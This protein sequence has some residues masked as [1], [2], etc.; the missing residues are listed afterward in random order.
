MVRS[1]DRVARMVRSS[2]RGRGRGRPG[3]RRSRRRR[4]GRGE[5]R[6]GRWKVSRSRVV[7]REKAAMREATRM[8]GPGRGVRRE[9]R[10]RRRRRRVWK[11]RRVSV[12]GWIG[13]EVEMMRRWRRKASEVRIPQRRE[14]TNW[15]CLWW[16]RYL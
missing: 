11:A 5:L 2:A 6:T 8:R 7:E 13:G 1:Q 3:R 10:R 16:F 9:G 15:A 4:G 12:R 14:A